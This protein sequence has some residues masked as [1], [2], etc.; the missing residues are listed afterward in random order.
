MPTRR[1]V[2]DCY[3]TIVNCRFCTV[4]DPRALQQ[5]RVNIAAARGTMGPI[6]PID[7]ILKNEDEVRFLLQG[8]VVSIHTSPRPHRSAP[9]RSSWYTDLHSSSTPGAP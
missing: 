4:E 6:I 1:T 9:H 7:D 3:S 2:F 5:D 8:L